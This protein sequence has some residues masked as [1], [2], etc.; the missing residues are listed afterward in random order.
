MEDEVL[1]FPSGAHSQA[2]QFH[3]EESRGIQEAAGSGKKK[4]EADQP[5]K[6]LSCIDIF[7]ASF[8]S[9]PILYKLPSSLLAGM[10]CLILQNQC[11][12]SLYICGKEVTVLKYHPC[13]F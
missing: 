2:D 8:S 5:G 7:L 9:T 10:P 6:G 13:S 4:L 1:L 11:L 3:N 12:R